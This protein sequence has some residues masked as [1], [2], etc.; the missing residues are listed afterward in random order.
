MKNIKHQS[1]FLNENHFYDGDKLYLYDVIVNKLSRGPYYIKSE[2]S[3]LPVIIKKDA[4]GKEVKT[5]KISEFIFNY[6]FNSKF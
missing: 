3:K 5:T 6:L 4:N 2:I 1:E